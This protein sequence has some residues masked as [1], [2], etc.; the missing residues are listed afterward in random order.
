MIGLIRKLQPTT[1]RAASLSIYKSYLRPCFN[2]G[3]V[4]YDQAF[5]EFFLNKLESV[6]YSAALAI[7]LEKIYQE[8]GLESLKSRR[9]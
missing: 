6:Q 5:N 1:P 8:F 4:I 9:W 3:D 2:Y 7:T